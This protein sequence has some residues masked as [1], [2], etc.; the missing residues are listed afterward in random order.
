MIDNCSEFDDRIQRL[1]D[2]KIDPETDQSI[3]AHTSVCSDCYESMMAYSL[4]HTNYLNDSD[5][6]KIKLEHLG[7]HDALLRNPEKPN[8][9]RMLAVATSIAAMLMLLAGLYSSVLL[10]GQPKSMS[11]A[12]IAPTPVA[13]EPF[14]QLDFETF[15]KIK[16]SIESNNLVVYTTELPGI[17]PFRALSLYL[18]WVFNFTQGESDERPKISPELIKFQLNGFY[19]YNPRL[20]CCT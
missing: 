12:S 17:K 8:H 20:L 19:S 5:S 1:M 16:H 2:E 9:K 18:D 15:R 6:M 4:L 10:K 7:L 14:Y 11:V 3:C 13:A